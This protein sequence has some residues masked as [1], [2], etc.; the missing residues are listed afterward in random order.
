MPS[1]PSLRPFPK[2][3]FQTAFIFLNGQ[4]M[5]TNQTQEEV[6]GGINRLYR[7]CASAETEELA[8]L[9]SEPVPDDTAH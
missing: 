5:I 8:E 1:T 2:D 9:G 3:S 4:D 7:A 6:G